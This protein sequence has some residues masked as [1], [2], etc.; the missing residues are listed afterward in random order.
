MMLV[1][2]AK[3]RRGLFATI[4]RSMHGPNEEK[5][6]DEEKEKKD[7]ENRNWKRGLNCVALSFFK[8]FAATR[9]FKRF[10]LLD[11]VSK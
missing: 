3:F 11:F 5:E 2:C 10:G 9:R 7:N 4:I 8:T 1:G 6:K